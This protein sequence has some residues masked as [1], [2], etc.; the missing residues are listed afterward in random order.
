MS[1]A[2][3]RISRK[4][5]VAFAVVVCVVLVMCGVVFMAMQTTE[6]AAAALD[7]SNRALASADAALAALVE[8]QNAVRGFVGTGDDTFV[9]T[10]SKRATEFTA[11]ADALAADPVAAG[12]VDDLKAAATEVWSQEQDQL[13][14]RR[15]P[16]RAAEAASSLK[17][18]GRLTKVRAVM[19]LIVD[20]QHA[21]QARRQA[22][23]AGAFR[24]A[25]ATLLIGALGAAGL[26]ALLGWLMTRAIAAPVTRMTGA[27]NKLAKGDL[28]AEIP[29]VGRRDEVGAMAAA[30]QVFK[31][32]G[33]ALQQAGAE[34]Q[35][36]EAQAAAERRRAEEIQ[37]ETAEQQAF[38]VRSVADGLAK[39]AEGDLTFRLIQ[40]FPGDYRKL[41]DDFNA[42]MSQLQD[43]MKVIV[44][45]AAAMTAGAGEI[46]QAADDLSRRTEQQA[47]TLE[48]TAAALDEITS[49]VRRTAEGAG[50]ANAVVVAA[51]ADAEKS[52]DVV[53]RAVTAMTGIER[54]SREISQI[55]GVIDEIAFQTNLLALNAGVEAARA[56]DAGKG[57]AV[58]AS[59]VRALAQRSADA[60]KEIKRL[61][62]TST[63]QVGEGVD[64]V[65]QAGQAL[66]RIAGQVTQISGL[67]SEIASSAQE[68][69]T[70]LSQVN[71]A[72]NQMDQT[73]Q[74]NAAMVE[75]STAASHALAQEADTLSGLMRRFQIGESGP[76]AN[77]VGFGARSGR[78]RA[79]RTAGS[80]A[81]LKP[82]AG[83]DS[84]E[85]F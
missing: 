29:A 14:M 70:G 54:S 23:E 60:A 21:E 84:W 82:D 69:A 10:Y 24:L 49:T 56:G 39:L 32:N 78:A 8:Q 63:Q 75:Q 77:D 36:L 58:V 3:L 73:T 57:F 65:G 66:D 22:D 62:S 83:P 42:V 85:E 46:S 55:I 41:Q 74:Q 27:M 47:A 61:I 18:H 12:H 71:T 40:D 28:S 81:L 4:I 48:E 2:D 16:T 30:V 38:V 64:L 76:A 7:R 35:R 44:Q 17:T 1:F 51:R 68:Q 80:S 26:A 52:G 79:L 20:G 59:E 43:A 5:T 31:D 19:K 33:L 72:V 67:V 25:S 50:Q 37:A 11:A 15:D 6:T 45:N 13:A 34:T 9:Q 53:G